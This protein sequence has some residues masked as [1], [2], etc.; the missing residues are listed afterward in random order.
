M[1]NCDFDF[2]PYSLHRFKSELSYFWV[3]YLEFVRYFRDERSD[4]F[5]KTIDWSFSASLQQRSNGQGGNRTI[6]VRY[7]ILQIQIAGRHSSRVRHG[8]L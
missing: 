3:E 2:L 7:Q 5:H 6:R 8:N 4:L 1:Q